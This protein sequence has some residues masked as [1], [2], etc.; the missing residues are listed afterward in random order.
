METKQTNIT[1]K[2]EFFIDETAQ[3]IEKIEQDCIQTKIYELQDKQT[4]L[5]SKK[6]NSEYCEL[7]YKSPYSSAY[8]TTQEAN[9]IK[10]QLN[11][12]QY[13]L[14][15]I[16]QRKF[17]IKDLAK[18]YKVDS[19]AISN[20]ISSKVSFITDF[21]F[22]EAQKIRTRQDLTNFDYKKL[23]IQTRYDYLKYLKNLLKLPDY[24]NINATDT[25]LRNLIKEDEE[26]QKSANILK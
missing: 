9:Q 3:L 18:M 15:P 7:E 25:L 2:T 13:F 5:K 23:P 14:I 24:I 16:P 8:F 21:K 11:K 26:L 19:K 4:K 17:I 1:A 22:T 10:R 20:F 6:Y 12:V